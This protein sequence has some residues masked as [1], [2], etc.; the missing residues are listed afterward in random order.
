MPRKNAR[1]NRNIKAA[2]KSFENVESL[3]KCKHNG[4]YSK[5]NSGDISY[6]FVQ[7]LLSSPLLSKNI[8]IKIYR[9]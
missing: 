9:L 7:N 2:N 4:R 5:L 8:N 6:N 1:Q 3:K